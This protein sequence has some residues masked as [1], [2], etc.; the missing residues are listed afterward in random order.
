M[1]VTKEVAG[2]INNTLALAADRHYEY[3][4]PELLLLVMCESTGF[5]RAFSDCGGSVPM[6][7]AKLE[8][9]LKEYVDTVGDAYMEY[10]STP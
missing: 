10:S 5:I 6:L 9:Y 7:S 8:E 1:N 4:T 3:A 2:I